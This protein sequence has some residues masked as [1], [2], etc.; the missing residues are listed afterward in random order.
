MKLFKKEIGYRIKS[1]RE[2]KG[3]SRE[4][5][6]EKL[7]TSRMS[8]YHWEIGYATPTYRFA[9]NLAE[10]LDVQLDYLMCKTE[11]KEDDIEE[12]VKKLKGSVLVWEGKKI[13]TEEFHKILIDKT[14]K[15]R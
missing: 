8:V 7:G 10:V 1:L 4:S 5:L 11:Q 3:L 13:S 2:E 15:S 14:L 9:M 12:F 6:A